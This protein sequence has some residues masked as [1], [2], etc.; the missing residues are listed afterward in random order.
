MIDKREIRSKF[1]LIGCLPKINKITKGI[2]STGTDDKEEKEVYL[3]ENEFSKSENSQ[4]VIIDN[5]DYS[6][7]DKIICANVKFKDIPYPVEIS[8][9]NSLQQMKINAVLTKNIEGDK[10]EKQRKN[11]MKLIKL[12]ARIAKSG[13][14]FPVSNDFLLTYGFKQIII[15]SGCK[16]NC[17]YCAVKFAKNKIESVPLNKLISQI[18][19]LIAQGKRKIVLV[20][21]DFGSWGIDLGTNWIELIQAINN[22]NYPK[23]EIG[24]FNIKVEDILEYKEIVDQI[25]ENGK[26][27]YLCVMSQHVNPRILKLMKRT[28]FSKNSFVALIN[29][30]GSK[31]VQVETF[32]IVGFPSETEEE[33]QELIEFICEVDTPHFANYSASFSLRYGTAACKYDNKISEKVIMNRMKVLEERYIESSIRRFGKLPYNLQKD[34]YDMLCTLR[35]HA[36]DYDE[37]YRN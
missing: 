31:D 3:I 10:A 21:D 13:F 1:F 29:E 6:L 19:N 34:L 5:Y 16:N 12:Q 8:A 23:L 9:Q 28:V 24:I 7:L 35:E 18:E 17:A 4:F 20:A 30:Y 33:F 15:G 2:K 26:L 11:Y 32:T 22:I 27:K 36:I 25:V 37:L 14:L